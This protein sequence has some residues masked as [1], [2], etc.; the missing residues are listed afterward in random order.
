MPWVNENGEDVYKAS[1]YA[2]EELPTWDELYSEFYKKQ[3]FF[4]DPKR[5]NVLDP[6][7][8][9]PRDIVLLA[10]CCNQLNKLIFEDGHKED[11][12]K[13][14]NNVIYRS[15]NDVRFS[16]YGAGLDP[17]THID[18][19]PQIYTPLTKDGEMLIFITND[20]PRIPIN[21]SAYNQPIYLMLSVSH[22][23][24]NEVDGIDVYYEDKSFGGMLE[25]QQAIDHLLAPVIKYFE[26][27][28][29]PGFEGVEKDK[30]IMVCDQ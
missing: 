1:L 23:H 29:H 6:Y 5:E 27:E 12:I 14:Y 22:L 21:R 30:P 26:D 13:V 8:G 11:L 28:D 2:K 15:V 24:W 7:W 16:L 9:I 10:T 3:T 18:E 17:N 19:V 20:H 25:F 4:Y